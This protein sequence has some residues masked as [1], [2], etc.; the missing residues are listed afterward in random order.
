MR[1]SFE[2]G[3]QICPDRLRHQPGK[4][5]QE[6]S[7]DAGHGQRQDACGQG[8][9]LGDH[10]LGGHVLARSVVRLRHHKISFEVQRF[11]SIAGF[12]RLQCLERKGDG[13]HAQDAD[14]SG[15]SFGQGLRIGDQVARQS[16]SVEQKLDIGHG[17]FPGELGKVPDGP[18]QI[19]NGSVVR[20]RQSVHDF[21]V[22][23]QDD[24]QQGL[25]MFCKGE[26][27]ANKGKVFIRE[28]MRVV[29]KEQNPLFFAEQVEQNCFIFCFR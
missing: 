15:G 19:V 4:K 2:P 16:R 11:F 14:D 24:L 17:L 21:A 12:L 23:D 6:N 20:P 25:Q 7:D 26:Q 13:H 8:G 29:D 3:E 10:L 9:E 22:S 27:P 1:R 18:E 28:Q 5:Q